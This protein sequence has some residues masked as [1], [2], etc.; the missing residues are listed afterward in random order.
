MTRQVEIPAEVN[1]TRGILEYYGVTPEGKTHES[2]LKIL[3]TPSHI[4]L[5]LI[6][7]GYEPSQYKNLSPKIFKRKLVKRGDLLR[8][9]LKWRPTGLGRDQWILA[10]MAL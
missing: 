2:V 6:L 10:S 4:H 8:L 1:M 5:A 9:Y 3:A 7:A